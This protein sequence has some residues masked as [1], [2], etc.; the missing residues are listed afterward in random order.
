AGAESLDQPLQRRLP[1][2]DHI[3]RDLVAV[4][5]GYS[6][7]AEEPGS[8]GFAAGDAACQPDAEYSCAQMLL[9]LRVDLEKAE[10]ARYNPRFAHQ[11]QPTRGSQERPEGHGA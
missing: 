7:R 2:L 5:H 3:A 8:R 11:H 9:R 10:V 4:E 1:G 6:Q